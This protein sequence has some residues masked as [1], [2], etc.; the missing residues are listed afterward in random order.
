M[1]NSDKEIAEII[2]DIQDDD[3]GIQWEELHQKSTDRNRR[4]R[5]METSAVGN[6]KLE[7]RN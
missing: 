2:Y 6:E 4:Y 5:F 3:S 1:W 7:I